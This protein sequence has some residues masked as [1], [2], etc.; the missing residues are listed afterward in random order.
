M[1][2]GRTTSG[3]G[4]CFGKMGIPI[5]SYYSAHVSAQHTSSATIVGKNRILPTLPR[6]LLNHHFCGKWDMCWE[7]V[8]L[9]VNV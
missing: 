1:H 7:I 2:G 9:C 5:S 3:H 4:F 8:V 6:H